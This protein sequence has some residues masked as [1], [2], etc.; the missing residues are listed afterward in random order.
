MI[1]WHGSECTIWLTRF[2]MAL[3]CYVKCFLRYNCFRD[4][5]STCSLV[6]RLQ[7]SIFSGV[8]TEGARERGG[9][10]PPIIQQG[11]MALHN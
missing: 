3:C 10:A 7:W 5:E 1:S 6:R 4:F 2:M 9:T 8:G 11:G